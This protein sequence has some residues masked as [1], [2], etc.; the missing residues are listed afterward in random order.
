MILKSRAW[1]LNKN[2]FSEPWFVPDD[3]FYAET[4]SKAKSGFLSTIDGLNDYCHNDITFLSIRVKRSKE[5]DKYLIDGEVKKLYQIEYD[6]KKKE[7]D[8]NLDL[9][10]KENPTAKAYIIKG[11]VYYRPKNSGYS[12]YILE[13]GIYSIQ[14]AVQSV[15]MC[16]LGD[17]M[18]LEII[19]VDEHNKRINDKIENLKTRLI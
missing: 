18:R 12:E 8:E 1:V 11:G 10:L 9:I 13:A 16:S 6:R 15:K 3:V 7:R 14:D 5:N 2:I 17:N 4:A 19:D